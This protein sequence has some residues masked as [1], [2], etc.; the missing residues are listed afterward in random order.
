MTF[1]EAKQAALNDERPYRVGNKD[2][3]L[4]IEN[5]KYGC[6][7]AL[8]K[9]IHGNSYMCTWLTAEDINANDWILDK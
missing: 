1:T 9:Q 6:E 7:T 3:F 2:K 8:M 5:R 4:C